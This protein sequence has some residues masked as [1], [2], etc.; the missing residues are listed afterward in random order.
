MFALHT[1]KMDDRLETRDQSLL[2]CANA[3]EGSTSD[4]GQ[5]H[6]LYAIFVNAVVYKKL[7]KRQGPAI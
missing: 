6:F 4:S 7:I 5:L 3:E 1:K 2:R